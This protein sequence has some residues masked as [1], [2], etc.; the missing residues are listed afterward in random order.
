VPWKSALA[1]GAA[2]PALFAVNGAT[3]TSLTYGVNPSV[4]TEFTIGNAFAGGGEHFNGHIRS[5][6]YYPKRLSAG[7]LQTLTK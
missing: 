6:A 2:S 3:Q 1:Y 5:F 7:Q 4:F